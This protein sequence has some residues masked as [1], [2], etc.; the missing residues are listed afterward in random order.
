MGVPYI[1]ALGGIRFSLSSMNTEEEI[2]R[3]LDLLPPIVEKARE[4]SAFS[5]AVDER[6]ASIEAVS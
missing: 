3:V 4:V 5:S 1:S 6:E 2:D